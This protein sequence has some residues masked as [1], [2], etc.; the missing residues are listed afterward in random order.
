M[1]IAPQSAPVSRSTS[2]SRRVATTPA[3][4]GG[5][6]PSIVGFG[7]PFEGGASPSIV[8]FGLPFEGGASPSIVGFGLPFEA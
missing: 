8:G 3:Q 2:A 7:L 6:S 1:F 5:V 4:D